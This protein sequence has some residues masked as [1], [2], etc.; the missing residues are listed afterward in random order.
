[1]K[2]D[3]TYFEEY[4][5]ERFNGLNTHMNSQFESVNDKLDVINTHLEKQNGSIVELWKCSDARKKAVDEFYEF[6]SQVAWFKKKWL[7][8]LL[9][10]ILLICLVSFLYDVGIIKG[11]IEK[12]YDKV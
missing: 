9:G 12:I 1:M 6:K 11:L 5:N 10:L 4:L 8:W 7:I 2:K 3:D